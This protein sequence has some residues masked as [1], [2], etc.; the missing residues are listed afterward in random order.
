MQYVS[1][2]PATRLD[3]IRLQVRAM[4]HSDRWHDH[5]SKESTS[6]QE[7]LDRKLAD[8]QARET[9]ICVVREH[10]YHQ[11]FGA[12]AA[13]AVTMAFGNLSPAAQQMS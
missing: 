1:K 13:L 5:C 9:G 8:R 12:L 10:L 6:C 4:W 7:E 3:V 11:A 2:E